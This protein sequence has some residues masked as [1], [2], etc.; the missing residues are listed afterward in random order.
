M[1]T[2]CGESR[3]GVEW[4]RVEGG[5]GNESAVSCHEP[6]PLTESDVDG[7]CVRACD[8]RGTPFVKVRDRVTYDD[9]CGG[10]FYVYAS[11]LV[12]DSGV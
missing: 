3:N 1:F 4:V 2:G 10:N 9:G 5:G 6:V 8:P 11:A 12:S 7:C